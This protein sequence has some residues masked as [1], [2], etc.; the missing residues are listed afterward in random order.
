M[1]KTKMAK[2]RTICKNLFQIFLIILEVGG[3]GML[4]VFICNIIS[5]TN[6]FVEHI[7]RFLLG[8]SVYELLVFF[9]LTQINDSQKDSELAII[10]AYKYAA[11][12]CETG[13]EKIKDILFQLI[14]KQLEAVMM[15]NAK[16][17]EEYIDLK[18]HIETKNINYIKAR[19]IHH[20][21]CFEMCSLRWRYSFILRLFK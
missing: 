7:S 11:L 8:S 21:H 15:N 2:I 12:Y 3:I 20:E 5:P 19:I 4:V 9:T 14:D 1:E 16:T 18:K 10:G 6:D 13:D 17:R